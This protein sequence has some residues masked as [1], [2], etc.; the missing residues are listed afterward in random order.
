MEQSALSFLGQKAYRM[1]SSIK[2]V[3]WF[4]LLLI[5]RV[6]LD[7]DSFPFGTKQLACSFFSKGFKQYKLGCGACVLKGGWVVFRGSPILGPVGEVTGD[8][9]VLVSNWLF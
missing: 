3:R 1:Q 5:L 4:R 6:S 8:G 2:R 7:K 9:L